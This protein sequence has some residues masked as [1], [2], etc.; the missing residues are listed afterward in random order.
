MTLAFFLSNIA[1]FLFVL[2]I[3]AVRN[4]RLLRPMHTYPPAPA[5][6]RVAVLVPAR[7]EEANIEACLTSLLAQDYPDFEVWA[8]DDDSTDATPQILANLA[9]RHPR[10]H[11]LNGAPLP[12]G[13]LG[14]AW[15]CH[16][17]AQHADADLLL[18]TDA[19]TRHHPATLREAVNA[20]IATRS[21][22]LSA[23]PRELTV[24]WGEKLIIPLVPW[25]ILAFLPLDLG[26][27]V[28]PW[29]AFSAA[30]GQFMLFRREAY[31]AIGGHAAVRTDVVED[32]ALARR[33][34]AARRRLWLVDAGER[35]TCRMYHNLA[36][37][38]R[39]FSKNFYAAF[40]YNAPLL[41]F[42]W[43]WLTLVFWLP[44][45]VLLLAPFGHPARLWASVSVGLALLLWGFSHIKYRFPLYLTPL[46]PVMVAFADIIAL[47]SWWLTRR[48][49]AE[50]KG[51]LLREVGRD[52]AG[53]G[54]PDR[55]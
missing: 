3:I 11:V 52:S 54:P 42:I 33:I 28:L 47:R 8:L 7:N 14:K 39:G 15:A 13:W 25:T 22:L 34:K 51:R 35:V 2:V 40:G 21:D 44:L 37:V 49:H 45:L 53:Q 20:L 19:D 30:N 9:A 29:P 32:L 10:L 1:A 46:Y 18:F 38:V 17:L 41:L 43:S 5:Y 6:P 12:P 24:T 50:W 36:E 4:M 31:Q 23:T 16:Q 26:L 48:G 27:R 55:T